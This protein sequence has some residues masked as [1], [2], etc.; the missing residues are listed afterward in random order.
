MGGAAIGVC[1]ALGDLAESALKRAAQV[2]DSGSVIPGRGGLLDSI[3]SMLLCAPLFFFWMQTV[4]WPP[5]A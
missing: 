2:K 4:E 1:G 5:A 3:D